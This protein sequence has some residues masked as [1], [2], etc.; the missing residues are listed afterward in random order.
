MALQVIKCH[1]LE[2][3]AVHERVSHDDIFTFQVSLEHSENDENS[4]QVFLAQRESLV[5]DLEL[6]FFRLEIRKRLQ[7]PRCCTYLH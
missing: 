6:L 2:E 4:M 5:A 1:K 7:I 3:L